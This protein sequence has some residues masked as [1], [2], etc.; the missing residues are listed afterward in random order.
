MR[1][2]LTCDH[3]GLHSGATRYCEQKARV[4][5]VIVCDDCGAEVRELDSVAYRPRFEPGGHPGAAF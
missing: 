1:P 3:D 2:F 4:R 5:Y